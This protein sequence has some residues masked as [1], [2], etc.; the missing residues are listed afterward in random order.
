M[1]NE[2]DLRT[3]AIGEIRRFLA[4]HEIDFAVQP[5]SIEEENEML[6]GVADGLRAPGCPIDA[7]R[8]KVACEVIDE[9]LADR[10]NVDTTTKLANI[11]CVIG[12]RASLKEP[13]RASSPVSV[14]AL[15]GAIDR[16]ISLL[17]QDPEAPPTQFRVFASSGGAG[18][19]WFVRATSRPI[20][21]EGG[22]ES[23]VEAL[24]RCAESVTQLTEEAAAKAEAT[25]TS[26]RNAAIA[27]RALLP[28]KRD[29]D[30]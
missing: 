24:Q 27:L 12:V 18:A 21:I 1:S 22:G 25:V 8:A 20:T 3:R 26:Q 11:S 10:I 4:L 7:A 29:H 15:F 5:S 9:V 19:A 23:L 28:T 30:V 2:Q 17:S 14:E 6:R 13:R 16:A